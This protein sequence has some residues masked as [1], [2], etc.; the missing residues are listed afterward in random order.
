ML[1]LLQKRATLVD[2][3][4]DTLLQFSFDTTYITG[5]SN[6]LADALSRQHDRDDEW[7]EEPEISLRVVSNEIGV[8]E[9]Q[10]SLQ[11]ISS[12]SKAGNEGKILLEAERRG[13]VAPSENER[14]GLIEKAHL[15]GHFGVQS[16]FTFLFNEGFLL[17][18]HAS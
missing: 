2:Y 12:E 9:E 1:G 15:L 14:V 13:K 4:L 3:W 11:V 16:T 18:K 5:P 10:I 7:K 6:D 17:A 8:D